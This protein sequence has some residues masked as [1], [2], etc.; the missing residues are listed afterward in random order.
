MF[1]LNEYKQSKIGIAVLVMF[2]VVF[3]SVFVFAHGGEDHSADSITTDGNAYPVVSVMQP[4]TIQNDDNAFEVNGLVQAAN[5]A[6]IYPLKSGNVTQLFVNTGDYVKKGQLIATITPEKSDVELSAQILLLEQE[7]LLLEEQKQIEGNNISDQ[8]NLLENTSSEKKNLLITANG[9][10]NNGLIAVQQST[11]ELAKQEYLNSLEILELQIELAKNRLSAQEDIIDSSA[12]EMFGAI[13]DFLYTD[14]SALKS[15]INAQRLLRGFVKTG[16]N[17]RI[18]YDISGDYITLYKKH[19]SGE[20]S[21]QD[22]FVEALDLAKRVRS[23]AATA[24]SYNDDEDFELLLSTLDSAM[25]HFGELQSEN[26]ST[27]SEVRELEASKVVNAL[28]LKQTELQINQ[29]L[30]QN[31]LQLNQSTE[32]NN[33]NLDSSVKTEKQQLE[34]ERTLSERR[35][36]TEMAGKKAEISALKAQ[37]GWGS[38]VY[39]PFDGAVVARHVSV[40]QS[41]NSGTGLF[42]LV[43]ESRKFIRFYVGED[44]FPF[45]EEGKKITFASQFTPSIKYETEI[46]RVARGL[47]EN[48]KQILVEADINTKDGLE[49]VLT[50]MNVVVSVPLFGDK[51]NENLY[52][53]SESGLRLGDSSSVWLVNS[54][55]AVEKRELVVDFIFNGNAYVAE[56]L[57]GKE[58][59]I[60][61][62][63][64]ELNDG[65][66]V[67]TKIFNQ[68]K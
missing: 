18:I 43:D 21:K 28:K 66:E 63:P 53:I 35:I 36:E 24:S 14:S 22:I 56:G 2:A 39:A 3:G 17:A 54:D 8:I 9:K 42:S 50:N 26:L 33:L 15:S 30:E 49:R 46:T 59:V 25:D 65:L 5:Q 32:V 52:V 60:V 4:R 19:Q 7:L 48:N 20:I 40:G 55:V 12:L 57:S 10:S 37:I 13:T 6:E 1:K 41:V 16:S 44:Q 38:N 61:Q 23:L 68:D 31:E 64:V 62:S 58:W 34:L 27:L 51:A 11:L 47:S 45:I 29:Q 67:E